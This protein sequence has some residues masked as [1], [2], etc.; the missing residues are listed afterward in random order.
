[1][2]INFDPKLTLDGLMTLV[3]GIIAF[4]AILL[5]IRSSHREVES[6]LRADKEARTTEDE[7]RKQAVAKALLF[8]I[9]SFYRYYWN[10]L[11]PILDRLDT[12]SCLPPSISAPSSD[13]FVV[14]RGNAGQLGAFDH[15][16]VEKAVRFYGL[17]EWLLSSV[18]AYMWSLDRE[19]ERQRFVATE[20]APRIM[21]KQIQ[22]LM[23]ETD[24]A[25]VEAMKKLCETTGISFDSLKFST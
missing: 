8:E 18:R 11:R 15:I 20:S 23:Y 12:H 10:H 2:S 24:S 5:Q 1:M 17:G 7:A 13:F 6:Q 14:Y 9:V 16:L 21:L 19:L 4:V 3:A 25:A 22:D